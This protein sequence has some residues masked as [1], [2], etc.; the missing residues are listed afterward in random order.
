MKSLK[1]IRRELHRIPEKGFEEVKTQAYL[2]AQIKL[3]TQDR[4]TIHT[5][6]TGFV[7][8]VEGL[9]PTK[10]IGWRTDID[11]LP[12]QE[13]TDVDYMS[14][15]EGFMHACGHDVH[16]TIALGLLRKVVDNPIKDNL[17]FL[18]Q[19]AEEGPGGALPMRE[20][21]K[22][23]HI[24][25]LPDVIFAFHIAPEYPVRTIATRPGLLFANTSEL[26]ID[27]QGVEGHAAFPHRTRDMTIASAN[28]LM[29]LQTI[30]S[31][32]INPLD[33][34]VVTIGKMTS[35]TVQNIISGHARLEGTIR[36]MNANT[37][38][39]VKEKI[40]AFCQATELAFDC[41]VLID[42]GS[43]Y[44]QVTN[45]EYLTNNFLVFAEQDEH[46]T[47][48]L[49]DAAM[50]GEDFGYFL[51][52]IP[53]FLFWAGVDSKYGLH[54]AKLDPNEEVID[55]LIPFVESYLRSL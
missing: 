20:W 52:E 12:I 40:E 25:C 53:G 37:M 21:L 18:F 14:E 13:L 29:Q 44:Y 34:A 39:V 54:H 48:I 10:T 55:Y 1:D 51:Q 42:Y 11:G 4:L 19:P 36:T 33:S 24:D 30:V 31:R 28:L 49:C 38:K 50:T 45:E 43:S 32:S 6:K 3:L 2:L 26:F 5:W 35:G 8:K 27:L 22:Q 16:M 23:D 9:L 47:A 41:K 46:T 7:V 15:H 17:V